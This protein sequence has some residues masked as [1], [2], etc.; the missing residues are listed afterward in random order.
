MN[1]KSKKLRRSV[2]LGCCIMLTALNSHA[3]RNYRDDYEDNDNYNGN[4][5]EEYYNDDGDTN[6]PMFKSVTVTEYLT[7]TMG[8]NKK[9]NSKERVVFNKAG[10]ELLD[11]D[12][13]TVGLRDSLIFEYNAKG[14]STRNIVYGRDAKGHIV[15]SGDN[16][17]KYD[18]KG[19]NIMDS[20][21][22]LGYGWDKNE[23]DKEKSKPSIT[24]SYAKF[25]SKGNDIEDF[26]VDEEGDTSWQYSKYDDSNRVVYSEHRSGVG[27]GEETEEVY[28]EYY[29][30]NAKGNIVSTISVRPLDTTSTN[31]FYDAHGRETGWSVFDNR[32]PIR[33][34]VTKYKKDNDTSYGA[35]TVISD[36]T[37]ISDG[38]SCPNNRHDVTVY[39][40]SSRVLSDVETSEKSGKPF[41]TTVIHKYYVIGN[42]YIDTA[43]TTEEGYLHSLVSIDIKNYK[44][45]ARGNKIE[46]TEEGGGYYNR[47]SK[48]TWKYNEQN[49]EIYSA[50]YSSCNAEVPIQTDST[51]YY[52]GGKKVMKEVTT[53]DNSH[54]IM[55]YFEDGKKKEQLNLGGWQGGT[56]TIYEY[57][58]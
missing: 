14:N 4:G 28:S 37:P 24:Y 16:I 6:H 3:Q 35:R 11:V 52:P 43:I 54:Y 2:L 45:D 15:K 56:Q 47:T 55:Y 18:A 22:E 26:S 50:Q 36:N 30:Y 8:N 39:D 17:W 5:C 33:V 42:L 21:W 53:S 48:N 9:F 23:E 19:N 29:I 41:T 31:Y 10:Q 1:I 40:D 13:D 38:L 20:T 46:Q 32:I 34:N 51:F 57:E 49:K 25:D 44:N 7:D 27:E 12:I 58:K